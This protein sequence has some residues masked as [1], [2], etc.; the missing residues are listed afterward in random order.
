MAWAYNHPWRGSLL[1]SLEWSAF[2]FV[3]F[4]IWSRGHLFL[5]V[6]LPPFLLVFSFLTMFLVLRRRWFAKD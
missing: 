5:P 1:Y 3:F 2:M 6:V 4:L